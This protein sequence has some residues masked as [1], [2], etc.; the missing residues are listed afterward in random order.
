MSETTVFHWFLIEKWLEPTIWNNNAKEQL[1]TTY[2][3]HTTAVVMEF[4][5]K[6]QPP[7]TPPLEAFGTAIGKCSFKIKTVSWHIG[8][9]TS[10]SPS[11]KIFIANCLSMISAWF[12]DKF[13]MKYHE[14]DP[15]ISC[16]LYQFTLVPVQK[17]WTTSGFNKRLPF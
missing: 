4:S 13:I 5:L 2:N 14:N 15:E 8:M 10:D 9:P 17:N 16:N 3:K 11:H 1:L 12:S 6:L 7:T